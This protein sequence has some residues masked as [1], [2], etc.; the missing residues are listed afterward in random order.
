MCGGAFSF[1]HNPA[2]PGIIFSLANL[3]WSWFIPN[4]ESVP[5]PSKQDADDLLRHCLEEGEVVPGHIIF[6]QELT[7]EGLAVEDDWQVL[8]S[9]RIGIRWSRI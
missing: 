3:S 6:R 9:G 4:T 8:K 7:N 1:S 2:P 5:C